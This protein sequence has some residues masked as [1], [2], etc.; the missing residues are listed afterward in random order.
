MSN[1]NPAQQF[2]ILSYANTWGDVM[3]TTNALVNQNNDLASNNFYKATGTLYLNDNT[4]G[5]Q[6]ANNATIAGTLRVQG[7]GSS[8]YIQNSLRVDSQVYF[9]NTTL[10]L[11]NSGQANIGGPLYVTNDTYTRNLQSSLVIQSN[12]LVSNT[13]QTAN[14]TVTGTQY[15]NNVVTLNVISSPK[16]SI[17]GTLDANGAS[18]YFSTLQ[19]TGQLVVGG[20]FTINGQTV[21]NANT[22]TLND[23]S[24][25][26][27]NSSF[28]VNRGTSGA[29][30]AIRWNEFN[31]LFEILDV[32]S[33]N[34]NT[35]LTTTYL[36][37]SLT[38]T[39]STTAATSAAANTLNSNIIS[40]NTQMKSYVDSAVVTAAASANTQLKSY[41]DG[42]IASANTQLKSYTDGAIASANTQM[43][44]YVDAA[45]TQL[46][47][48]GDA[49]YSNATNI[50]SGT[51]PS[52]RLG[53]GTASSATYLRGDQVWSP[54]P[55]ATTITNETAS[56]STYYPLLSTSTTGTLAT[57]NTS[58]TKFYYVPS[59]GTL[60][61]TTFSGSGGSLTNLSANNLFGTVPSSVLANSSYFIGTTSISLNRASA[62]QSLTGIN[63]DG[64]AA[65]ANS[66]NSGNNYQVNSLGVGTAASGTAGEIR[67]TNNITA[68]YSDENLKTKLGNIE[69]ALEKVL[70]LNGFYYEANKT[71][72]DL[73]YSV[74]KE[75]GV[76]AQEVQKVLPEIVTAAPIDDKYLT[77]YYERLV[78]LLIEA[79]KELKS[80]ID[81]LKGK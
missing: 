41:T 16:V 10:G 34:Y 39:S 51:I 60:T 11:V 31:K 20:N 13:I 81:L 59:T 14:L 46:K 12:T 55:A 57:A 37:S 70:S 61:A 65:S 53:S 69:N 28:V 6:V 56:G 48:Y 38:S 24:T 42:A 71:A 66:L 33:N 45:N 18:G 25:I 75:V 5:L 43:K 8:A 44:S 50:T 29:N 26:G 76:S 9:T 74:K 32:T 79:I 49:T 22:F 62:A 63:I 35:I 3:V 80:E 30:A 58:S 7:I 77:V 52:A 54:I 40:A 2:K 36:S 78:P 73:G 47:T 67:A 68:Y 4:L 1:Y 21:Y 17:T 27:L 15:V 64:Y 19:T 23:G 72:Q